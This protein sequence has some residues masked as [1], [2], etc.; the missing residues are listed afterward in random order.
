MTKLQLL[1]KGNDFLFTPKSSG[2]RKEWGT[3]KKLLRVL[4]KEMQICSFT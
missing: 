4:G 2:V 3:F 1:L